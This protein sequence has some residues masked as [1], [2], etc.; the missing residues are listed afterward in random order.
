MGGGAR[1]L[2]VGSSLV[3]ECIVTHTS[4]P[5]TAVLWYHDNNVLDYDAP[6]GGIS[7]QVSQLFYQRVKS[8]P[9]VE[10]YDHIREV[11]V[12]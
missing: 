8:V 12:D 4:A 5:P 2:Q 7:L 3:L 10:F 11:N 6:R 9:R 1:F